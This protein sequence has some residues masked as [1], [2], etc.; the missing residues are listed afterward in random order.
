MS[1]PSRVRTG[2]GAPSVP[3]ASV[4]LLDANQMS[5]L[6]CWRRWGGI[7]SVST[8]SSGPALTSTPNTS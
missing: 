5:A 4:L 2:G 6:A 7:V 8:L 3:P 1:S